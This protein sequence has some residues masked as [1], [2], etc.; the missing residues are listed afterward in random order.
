MDVHFYLHGPSSE[1]LLCSG[2]IGLRLYYT[3]SDREERSYN[4]LRFYS[5][6]SVDRS[7]GL[8]LTRLYLDIGRVVYHR[9]YRQCKELPCCCGE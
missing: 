7:N 5:L 3:D 1:L 8:I 9:G 6:D 4:G 2:N